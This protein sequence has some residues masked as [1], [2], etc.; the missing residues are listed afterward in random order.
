MMC[1]VRAMT[2]AASSPS[3]IGSTFSAYDSGAL[4]P[5]IRRAHGLPPLA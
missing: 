5:G 1:V 3:P 4:R 2:S